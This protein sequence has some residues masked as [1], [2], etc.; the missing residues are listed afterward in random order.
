MTT[1]S[2]T[3]SRGVNPSN[4]AGYKAPYPNILKINRGGYVS[5]PANDAYRFNDGPFSVMAYISP[6]K[7]VSGNTELTLGTVFSS[8]PSPGGGGNGG[9]QLLLE[10]VNDEYYIC[11]K[12]DDGYGY[13]LLR[14]PLNNLYDNKTRRLGND[15]H[16]KEKTLTEVLFREFTHFVAAVNGKDGDLSI[17]VNGYLMA[18]ATSHHSKQE[19][20]DKSFV[21]KAIYKEAIDAPTHFFTLKKDKDFYNVG[22]GNWD[23]DDF[24]PLGERFQLENNFKEIKIGAEDQKNCGVSAIRIQKISNVTPAKGMIPSEETVVSVIPLTREFEKRGPENGTKIEGKVIA[25][26][27]VSSSDVKSVNNTLG[28]SI[29][30]TEQYEEGLYEGFVKHVSLWKTALRQEEIVMYMDHEKVEGEHPDC[31][32][33]WKL[34]TDLE[35]SSILRNHGIKNGNI[36]F[37]YLPHILPVYIEEQEKENWCWSA[38]GLAIVEFYDPLSTKTQAEIVEN[39][40]KKNKNDFK[41]TNDRWWYVGNYLREETKFLRDMHIRDETKRSEALN[42]KNSKLTN[43]ER[44]DILFNFK[45]KEGKTLNLDFIREEV[46]RLNPLVARVGWKGGGGHFMLITGLHGQPENELVVI[47]DP[48]YGVSYTSFK[49]FLTRYQGSG[50][51]TDLFTTC[52]DNR[53]ITRHENFKVEEGDYQLCLQSSDGDLTIKKRTESD[54]GEITETLVTA[55]S[56]RADSFLINKIEFQKDGSTLIHKSKGVNPLRINK[57]ADGQKPVFSLTLNL[58]VTGD[59]WDV[60]VV[61]VTGKYSGTE[62]HHKVLYSIKQELFGNAVSV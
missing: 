41:D 54:T 48:W 51:L 30:R 22:Y 13:H 53:F 31:V 60:E 52:S 36:A 39:Q 49:N 18:R 11:F 14:A 7:E 34:E 2:E 10:K 17:Y 45:T 55:T 19:M 33:F 23:S 27:L 61:E 57:I 42:D 50:F 21:L 5:I 6:K 35:D 16:Q 24:H 3:S 46:Q 1:N 25:Q 44:D 59:D 28:L 40:S 62:T 15:D 56:R 20:D 26:L 47:S 8:K 32:G 38:T 58:K 4:E 37:E 9:W 43:D 12:T 29:G